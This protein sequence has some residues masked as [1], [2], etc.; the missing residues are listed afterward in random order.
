MG[1]ADSWLEAVIEHLVRRQG[2]PRR[3]QV[4]GMH[5]SDEKEWIQDLPL[6]RPHLKVGS[7]GKGLSLDVPVCLGS[8]EGKQL[9]SF[10]SVCAAVVFEQ[11]LICCSIAPFCFAVIA[12]VSTVLQVDILAILYTLLSLFGFYLVGK[13]IY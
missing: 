8:S 6:P 2:Q 3:A 9:L 10:I 11:T 12:V 7:G 4:H 13:Y 1:N 5:L